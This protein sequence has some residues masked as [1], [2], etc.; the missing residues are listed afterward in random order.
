MKENYTHISV[1]LDSS[2]S[3]GSIRNDTIGGFNTFLE[4]QQKA[5]GE[6]TFSL[7]KFGHE[8][9]EPHWWAS[10]VNP[11]I[12]QPQPTDRGEPAIDVQ[13]DFLDVKEV[14]M[15]NTENYV[16]YGGTP[17]LDTIGAMINLTGKKLAAL[18]EALR[19]SKV[20]FV[21][22]TDGEENASQKYDFAK[23]KALIEQQTNVY[24]W[25]FMFLGANQDAIGE[26]SKMGIGFGKTVTYATSKEAIGGTYNMLASKTMAFRSAVADAS[27]LDF[28]DDERKT[29]LGEK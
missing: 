16:P 29:A 15:L 8:S 18:P 28:T 11:E 5:E 20:L 19:P 13:F 7:A 23:V 22:I 3:M 14:P 27:V 21:I 25:E 24:K 6:A 9:Y 26:A 17:L 12:R 1:V 2:G 10:K 4:G